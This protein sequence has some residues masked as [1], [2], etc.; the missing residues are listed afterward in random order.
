MP[1]YHP[2][3]TG[4]NAFSLKRS[5]DPV[6][7]GH[8][9]VEP[10]DF[11]RADHSQEL[12][13]P[14]NSGRET[15]VGGELLER[16]AN[17]F[18]PIFFGASGVDKSQP[19][20]QIIAILVH[21]SER[22]RGMALFQQ[23]QF[24]ARLNLRSKHNSNRSARGLPRHVACSVPGGMPQVQTRYFGSMTYREESV[25]EFPAG[26]PGFIQEKRFVPIEVPQHSPLIFLQSLAQPTLCFLSFPI[27]V[28]DPE[29]RLAVAREDLLA[30]AL[31]PDRQPQLGTEVAVLAL[32]SFRDQ[33]PA[34]ANLMAPV[35]VNLK[36]QRA[37]QAIRQ[38]Q[39]YSH[40]HP[41]QPRASEQ[42][43]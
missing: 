41:V 14:P 36:T 35:V 32:L 20:A 6:T 37:L 27:L 42:L 26:L 9:P 2:A 5:A 10:I 25:F 30:L 29:Y 1:E 15:F 23:P 18:A 43:C 24:H 12:F 38:D 19:L 11:S 21:Q 40:Q 34:T 17:K 33:L 7:E 28:V 13:T 31:N 4:H 22:G 3:G 16:R 39:V 8:V